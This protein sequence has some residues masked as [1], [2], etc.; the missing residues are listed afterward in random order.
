MQYEKKVVRCCSY[1]ITNPNRIMMAE[2]LLRWQMPSA[3]TNETQLMMTRESLLLKI[4]PQQL[5]KNALV[6]SYKS[7]P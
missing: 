4:E 2:K 5:Q 3:Q 7:R 6:W 1:L